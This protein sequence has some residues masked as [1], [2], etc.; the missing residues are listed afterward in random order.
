MKHAL[1]LVAALVLSS[2]IGAAAGP[3]DPGQFDQLA[4]VALD[5]A[6]LS[7]LQ[8]HA[9]R[10]AIGDAAQRASDLWGDT[11][12]EG[13]Y[14]ETGSHE[15]ANEEALLLD[16]QIVAYKF[17]VWT[18]ALMVDVPGCTPNEDGDGNTYVGETCVQGR[19]VETVYL[20]S[21]LKTLDTDTFPEFERN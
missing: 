6:S 3:I 4:H 1:W 2:P 15:V 8:L 14:S 17:V 11:I 20:G 5:H 18:T 19:I 9:V 21:N 7:P 13:P 16:G 10:A 12:L